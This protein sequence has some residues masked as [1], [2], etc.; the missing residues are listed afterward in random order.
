[1][2]SSL[3]HDLFDFSVLIAEMISFPEIASLSADGGI[4]NAVPSEETPFWSIEGSG[5]VTFWLPESS[6]FIDIK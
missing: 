6:M 3:P 5:A 2:I 4:E 1:M